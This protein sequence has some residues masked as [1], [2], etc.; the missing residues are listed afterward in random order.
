MHL[1]YHEGRPTGVPTP[2]P[3]YLLRRRENQRVGTYSGPTLPS[4]RLRSVRPTVGVRDP[5]LRVRGKGL[6]RTLTVPLP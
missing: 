6:L 1:V 2:L 3:S 4:G 5:D